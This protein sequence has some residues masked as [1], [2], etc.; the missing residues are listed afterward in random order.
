MS[1]PIVP[2]L[3]QAKV[4]TE[5]RTTYVHKRSASDWVLAIVSYI[6]LGAWSII[7]IFPFIWMIVT[8]FKS[9]R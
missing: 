6:L 8:S 3:A 1:T 7:V 5:E 9:N 2:P 4:G